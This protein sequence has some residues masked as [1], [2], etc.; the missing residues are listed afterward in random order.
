MATKAL[1]HSRTYDDDG[2][3]VRETMALDDGYV[4]YLDKGNWWTYRGRRVHAMGYDQYKTRP[5]LKDTIAGF[6][7]L[8]AKPPKGTH[9]TVLL[10]ALHN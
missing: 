9:I 1:W 10:D 6:R 8:A 5:G 4:F 7:K 3:E 2:V